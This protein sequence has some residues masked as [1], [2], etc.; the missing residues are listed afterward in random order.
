MAYSF[1]DVP[2]LGGKVAIVTGAS[3]GIG[4]VT[5]R[6]LAIKGCHVILACRSRAKT[7]AAIA[8]LPDAARN[9]VEFAELDLMSLQSVRDFVAAFVA[10]NLP[11]HFLVNNAGIYAPST[12]A[13]S[14]DGIESQL[15]TNHVGH[16]ALTLGLLPVLEASAP[17]RVV[18]LSSIAHTFGVPKDIGVDFEAIHSRPDQYSP[19]R[20]YSQSKL[21][22]V[23]FAVE[24]SRRL[25]AKGVTN[26][27]VNALHPGVVRSDIFRNQPWIVR[28]VLYPFQR[29]PE[30]GAKTVLYVATHADIEANKWHGQY[31][32][33]IAK[34]SEA[35]ALANDENVAAKCWETTAEL[36]ARSAENA[37]DKGTADPATNN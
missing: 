26:V 13:L 30:D 4:L 25:A 2:Q 9:N 19:L 23:L 6:E 24:L 20:V 11:L 28:V 32:G 36:I 17:S 10:R 1:E 31:F 27:Y 14:V 37:R 8:T 34:H 7:D 12:F 29:S 21:A 22:N 3:A 16:V 5:A 15:A 35:S 18:I 33:P